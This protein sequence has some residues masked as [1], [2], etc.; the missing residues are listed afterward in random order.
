MI[1]RALHL[2]DPGRRLR[3][4]CP[5][6]EGLEIREY[7]A[8]E[9]FLRAAQAR[10]APLLAVADVCGWDDDVSDRLQGRLALC[11]HFVLLVVPDRDSGCRWLKRGASDFVLAEQLAG[12]FSARCE[13]L[14]RRH[15]QVLAPDFRN[16][17]CTSFLRQ[18]LHDIRNPLNCTMGYLELLLSDPNLDPR[19]REDLQ[20]ALDNADILFRLTDQLAQAATGE[21]PLEPP[22]P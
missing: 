19:H 15:Q 17:A 10:R 8:A 18:F 13:A 6:Q 7:S 1:R 3:P 21:E 5:I 9:E 22:H 14:L 12:E 4:H 16:R 11:D 20:L 2:L